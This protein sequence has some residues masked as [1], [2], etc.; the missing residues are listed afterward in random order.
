MKPKY[1]IKVRHTEKELY[2]IFND[3]KLYKR[4]EWCF[5]KNPKKQRGLARSIG[6][7]AKPLIDK[8]LLN[9]TTI[10][11]NR[12]PSLNILTVPTPNAS[13]FF[14]I[15]VIEIKGKKMSWFEFKPIKIKL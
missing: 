10:T 1:S 13:K 2:R 14:D 8:G 3:V 9:P 4:A 6:I 11:H 15:D 12:Y 7:R 5:P